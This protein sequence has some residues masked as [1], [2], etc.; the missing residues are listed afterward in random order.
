MFSKSI[1]P[2]IMSWHRHNI[3]GL[4]DRS[5]SV[6]CRR[7]PF[8]RIATQINITF[9]PR[10]QNNMPLSPAI[11]APH[12]RKEPPGDITVKNAQTSHGHTHTWSHTSIHAHQQMHTYS[13]PKQKH[14]PN[15]AWADTATVVTDFARTIDGVTV[16]ALLPQYLYRNI[17]TCLGFGV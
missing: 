11:T 13:H 9:S 14:Q 5:P 12:A 15:E 17:Q 8:N 6:D 3:Y 2:R 1:I 10:P 16:V 7:I 4:E